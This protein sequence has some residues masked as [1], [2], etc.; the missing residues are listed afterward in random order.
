MD[1]TAFVEWRRAQR[2]TH[3]DLI[4][5]AETRIAQALAPLRPD[6]VVPETFPRVHR[7]HLA[8]VWCEL[9]G[10][11][12]ELAPRAFACDG[13]RHGLE[14]LLRAFAQAG[15]RVAL[16]GDVYPVYWRIAA[17]AEVATSALDTFPDFDLARLLAQATSDGASVVLLP[18]PLKLHGRAWT[19]EEVDVAIRWLAQDGERRLMLDGVYAFGQ[20][21]EL[22]MRRLIATD[23]VFYLDSLSKGWL[24][25]LVFGMALVPERDRESLQDIFR[26]LHPTQRQLF[27]AR[28]LMTRFRDF[29]A[30]LAD[31]L[32]THRAGLVRRL[33]EAGVTARPAAQGYLIVIASDARALLEDHRVLTL[34]ASVFGST[35]TDLS[36]ASALP[37]AATTTP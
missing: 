20:S 21:L 27:Q 4:D 8:P 19:E 2:A 12:I 5:V 14:L 16:P 29:P 13:V 34:P 24:H 31:E 32:A 37:T 30:R 15:R 26:A 36:I 17:A 25:E 9:R 11:P 33:A 35:R 6:V 10:L 23:Q 1:F 7:C 22:A 18:A 3:T 28:E